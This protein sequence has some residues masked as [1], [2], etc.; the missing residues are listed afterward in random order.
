VSDAR[1]VSK[2]WHPRLETLT[3][4]QRDADRSEVL[5]PKEKP[6]ALPQRFD[7]SDVYQ[8]TDM[9]M[10]LILKE[11]WGVQ[12][13]DLS[14]PRDI[15]LPIRQLMQELSQVVDPPTARKYL[16]TPHIL[17]NQCGPLG[18][19][20]Q[21]AGQSGSRDIAPRSGESKR[22]NNQDH[23]EDH[24]DNESFGGGDDEGADKAHPSSRKLRKFETST[25]YSCPFRKRNPNKF[26]VRDHEPCAKTG[27][28]NIPNVK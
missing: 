6:A 26:N 21:H 1:D 8:L 2:T 15:W 4:S 9:M 14:E 22:K 20:S 13:K 5:P 24:D 16:E 3:G 11:G 27:F 7:N 19:S 18:S 10:N 12:V 17:V 25:K 23:G 28:T